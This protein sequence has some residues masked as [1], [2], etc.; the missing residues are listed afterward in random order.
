[1]AAEGT[2]EISGIRTVIARRPTL[3]GTFGIGLLAL[4]GLPP[5]SLFASELLMARAEFDVGLGWAAM[6]AIAAMVVVFVAVAGHAR[7]MLLG[8]PPT[9]ETFSA[10]PRWVSAPLVGALVACGL[11]GVLAWP[12]SQLL[13]AAAHV[14]AT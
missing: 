4:L 1:V 7:H 11:I 2:S 13:E 3:G 14:V 10:P 5:F 8:T 12:L 9:G 6:L